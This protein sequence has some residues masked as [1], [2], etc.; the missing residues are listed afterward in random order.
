MARQPLS[1]AEKIALLSFVAL[2]IVSALVYF[3]V[4]I[5]G[6]RLFSTV[7]PDGRYKVEIGQTRDAMLMERSVRLSV[8]S[9]RETVVNRKL[10][11][12][13]DLLDD[14]FLGL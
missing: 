1:N 11:Y 6:V 14:D 7:S 8:W 10:I 3:R 2:G 13:G 5:V 12:T 9:A 4:V